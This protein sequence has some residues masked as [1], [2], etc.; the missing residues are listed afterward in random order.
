MGNA[1]SFLL[2]LI[3]ALPFVAGLI[4][5]KRIDPAY[6]PFILLLGIGLLAE[7]ASRITIKLF[8]GNTVVIGVYS[9]I[10]A[11]LLLLL[12]HKWRPYAT[13]KR[14]LWIFGGICC[15]IW[16]TE[17]LIY[18]RIVSDFS[19]VFRVCYSF[20]VVIL[21]VNEINFLITHQNRNLLRNARFIFCIGFLV[22]FLYQILL[23]GSFYISTYKNPPAISNSIISL[24]VKINVITNLIY[25]VGVLLIPQKSFYNFEEK[26]I[27]MKT[28]RKRKD[29]M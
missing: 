23:E 4:K 26:L 16:I 1:A 10:E 13:T 2:S 9:L 18:W 11:L 28:P 24:Q 17:N 6:Y 8:G 5:L 3:V 20:L 27:S 22:Y 21:S 7:I 25:L 19:P 15:A 29:N 14:L 12:F